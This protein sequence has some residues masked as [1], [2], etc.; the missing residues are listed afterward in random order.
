MNVGRH[1]ICPVPIKTEME[2][3]ET[4]LLTS[5]SRCDVQ[6]HHA[7]NQETGRETLRGLWVDFFSPLH[8]ARIVRSLLP[9]SPLV[10]ACRRVRRA[11]GHPQ[12][13]LHTQTR[14][15]NVEDQP[16]IKNSV[17]MYM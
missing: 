16:T 4:R 8:E 15:S 1:I 11:V 17:L 5:K 12:G 3:V 7:P 9:R 13:F 2:A 10:L 6:D 14:G